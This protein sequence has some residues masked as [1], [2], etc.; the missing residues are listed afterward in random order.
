MKDLFPPYPT[1][2]EVGFYLS[3]AASYQHWQEAP[4]LTAVLCHRDEPE[5]ARVFRLVE[6]QY[7]EQIDSAIRQWLANKSLP[8][9]AHPASYLLALRFL[10]VGE[11]L[12]SLEGFFPPPDE[13][14]VGEIH[15][16]FL[17]EWWQQHGASFGVG[18]SCA[19]DDISL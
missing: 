10:T 4:W 15:R 5:R 17:F 16:R 14:K 7:A 1:W 11:V 3:T 2:K 8:E 6:A 19:N 9:L 12:G 18:F 13:A